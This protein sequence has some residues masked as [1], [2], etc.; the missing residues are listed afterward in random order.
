MRIVIPAGGRGSRLWPLTDRT[1]KPLLPLGREPILTH[2][3]SR[4]PPDAP[5]TLLLTRQL[6]PAFVRWVDNLSSERQCSLFIETERSIGG[7]PVTAITE[8]L[9]QSDL[10]EDLV[11]VM[12]DALLPFSLTEFLKG[13]DPET[14]RIAAYRLPDLA[15]ARR[16]GVVELRESGEVINFTEKPE[17]PRSPWVF[18]GCLYLPRRLFGLIGALA[19][20]RMPQMGNLLEHLLAVGERVDA[21][22]AAGNWCDVGTFDAY[23]SAHQ[24]LLDPARV[25]SLREQGNKLEGVVYVHPVSHVSNSQLRRTVVGAGA[26]VINCDL[27]NCIINGNVTIEGKLVR[28]RVLSPETEMEIPKGN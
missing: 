26:T 25:E 23:L 16:Y 12:G 2:I 17:E 5:V 10:R 14:V 13:S 27:E 3:L 11:I 8:Y 20:E 21:F 15:E 1:P 6:E 7:G 9:T 18:T 24:G 22:L 19:T 4:I 28:N